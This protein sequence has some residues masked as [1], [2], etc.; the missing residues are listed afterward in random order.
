MIFLSL[1]VGNLGES[2]NAL[3]TSATGG[4][5]RRVARMS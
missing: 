4:I 2:S 1:A 5:L 3:A